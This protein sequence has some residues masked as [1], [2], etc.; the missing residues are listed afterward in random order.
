[1]SRRARPIPKALLIHTARH[2][3]GTPVEDYANGGFSYPHSRTIKRVRFEPS[4][5]LVTISNAQNAAETLRLSALMFFDKTNSVASSRLKF[6]VGDRIVN[7]SARGGGASYRIVKVEPLFDGAR[8][9]HIE[10]MLV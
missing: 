10:V 7:T 1:M 9:H 2:E 8:L 5:E 4:T 3:Y 6:A